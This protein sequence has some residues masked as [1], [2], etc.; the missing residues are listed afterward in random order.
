MGHDFATLNCFSIL[1]IHPSQGNYFFSSSDP[2]HKL[3]NVM[4]AR[5]QFYLNYDPENQFL[6]YEHMR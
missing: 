5:K 4:F 3:S 2:E 1:N 6:V